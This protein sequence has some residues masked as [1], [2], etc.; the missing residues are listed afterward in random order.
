MGLVVDM[1]FNYAVLSIWIVE[2]GK[3]LHDQSIQHEEVC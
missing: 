3:G 2:Y 1:P